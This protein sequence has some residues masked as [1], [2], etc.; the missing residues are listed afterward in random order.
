MSAT[1]RIDRLPPIASCA[2]NVN[3]LGPNVRIAPTARDVRTAP[4]TPAQMA[5]S[6]IASLGP[7]EVRD[8][9]AH[10]Q[11]CLE[12][13]AQADQVVAE[14]GRKGSLVIAAAGTAPNE[15]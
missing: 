9:D 7:E 3:V 15:G 13:F 8:Q 1:A 14:H 12:A 5:G 2:S 10:D 11:R 6:E 4:P